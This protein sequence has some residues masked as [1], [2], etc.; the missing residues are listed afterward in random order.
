MKVDDEFNG[1]LPGRDFENDIP[2]RIFAGEDLLAR[3]TKLAVNSLFAGMSAESSFSVS[4]KKV[5][6]FARREA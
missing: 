3:D 4:I 2:T 6:T 5:G 1:D